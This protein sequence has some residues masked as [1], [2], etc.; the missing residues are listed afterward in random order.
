MKQTYTSKAGNNAITNKC[1]TGSLQDCATDEVPC[2]IISRSDS[3][4]AFREAS[5][6]CQ[7]RKLDGIQFVLS[8]K[9]VSHVLLRRHMAYTA[10]TCM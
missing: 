6:I 1:K 9:R 3:L 8:L 7:G 5:N 4:E 10:L 2:I